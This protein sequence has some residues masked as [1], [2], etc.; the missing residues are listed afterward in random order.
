MNNMANQGRTSLL[1]TILVYRTNSMKNPFLSD[2]KRYILT[3]T[4]RQFCQCFHSRPNQQVS[5]FR[6]PVFICEIQKQPI[7]FNDP[8]FA[9]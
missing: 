1:R 6:H 3:M 8:F 5:A 7:Y 4:S 2:N 9:D